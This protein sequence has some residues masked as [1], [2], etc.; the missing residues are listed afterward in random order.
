MKRMES[1]LEMRLG[2]PLEITVLGYEETR[3]G[4][5][6]NGEDTESMYDLVSFDVAWLA[7]LVDSDCLAPVD[8]VFAAFPEQEQA[9]FF[10]IAIE[11]NRS[12]DH[13]YGL[14]IQPH[15]ELLLYRKDLFKKA[16][17][18][19]PVTT[20]D[21]LAAAR[22]LHDPEK[23]MY[24]ICWNA[25][26]GHP[27]GQTMAHFYA[28]FGGSLLDASGQPTLDTAEGEV[29]AR[30]VL[31]LMDVSPPD[32]LFMAWDDRIARFTSGQ[33]VMTYGWGARHYLVE[34][35]PMSK[36]A[37]LAGYA[38]APAAPGVAP[39]TVLGQW[40]LGVPR[41]LDPARLAKALEALGSITSRETMFFL[42]E[43]G[44]MGVSR[45]SQALNPELADKHPIYGVMY[46][47]S[48][49]GRL[50]PTM[51]PA[52]PEWSGLSELMGTVFFEMLLGN[53]DVEE[54]LRVLQ[55]EANDLFAE[56]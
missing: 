51:R 48:R 21:L 22:R 54:T 9:D 44:H 19:V 11:V 35:D 31:E 42:S 17:L 2:Q 26:Q 12:G 56:N 50:D 20:D 41:N 36:V 13:L 47:L 46:D 28:A 40:S 29:A 49:E 14:P 8:T 25:H 1:E 18:S 45:Y 4:I 23:G 6:R 15:A 27:L 37:G 7:E 16:G 38:P 24:G 39:K 30:F 5:L 32:I 43:H 34:E 33:A 53:M 52:I 55:A 10:E 3:A